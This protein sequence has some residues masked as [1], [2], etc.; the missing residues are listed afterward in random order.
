MFSPTGCLSFLFSLRTFCIPHNFQIFKNILRLDFCGSLSFGFFPKS[1]LDFPQLTMSFTHPAFFSWFQTVV[2]LPMILVWICP[3][4]ANSCIF[5]G[6]H[7]KYDNFARC[8]CWCWNRHHALLYDAKAT[9]WSRF[10]RICFNRNWLSSEIFSKPHL[11]SVM[12]YF[13]CIILYSYKLKDF[14]ALSVR[15]KWDPV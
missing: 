9:G 11:K 14:L 7:Q 6:S 15:I 10:I 3:P 2:H 12:C 4:K 5:T 1:G 13:P 8:V